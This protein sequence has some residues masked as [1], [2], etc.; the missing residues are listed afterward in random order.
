LLGR[1]AQLIQLDEHELAHAV[2]V[3]ALGVECVLRQIVEA[4]NE[5]GSVARGV[6]HKVDV[7]RLEQ[8]IDARVPIVA[9]CR[10]HGCIERLL[11]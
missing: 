5:I 1:L 2:V 3:R 8:E 9:R 4:S 10:L 11:G 7:P 6:P